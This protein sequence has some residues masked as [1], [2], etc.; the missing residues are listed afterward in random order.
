[1]KK[2]KLQNL[3]KKIDSIDFNVLKLLNERANLTIKIGKIKNRDGKSV[4]APDRE[5]EVYDKL[6]K[7]NKL[8]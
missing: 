1:M 6:F 7:I 2:M 3:R 5:R 8:S 4:F